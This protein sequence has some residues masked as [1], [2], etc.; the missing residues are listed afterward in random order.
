MG[1]GRIKAGLLFVSG[2]LA[3]ICAGPADAR[4]VNFAI[5]PQPL[6]AALRAFTRATGRSVVLDIPNAANID[7]PGVNG[8]LDEAPALARLLGDRAFDIHVVSGG[9]VVR[10][11]Q[12]RPVVTEARQRRAADAAPIAPE[13]IVVTAQRRSE[14]LLEVPISISTV[15]GPVLLKSGITST[16]FLSQIAPGIVTVNNGFGYLPIVRG[17]Q[18]TGTS[19]GDETNI[20]IYIDDVSIG[21]PIAGFFDLTDLE[22]VEVLKG[23]Q[24]TLYGRNA[25]GGAI[26]LITRRP[27]FD[28]KGSIS[29]DFGFRY[30]DFRA[31][32]YA[33]GKITEQLAGLISATYHVGDGYIRGT[34][35]NAGRSYGGPDNHVV[36]AKLLWQPSSDF[37]AILSG[38]TWRQQNDSVFISELKDRNNPYPLTAGTIP[39][40]PY[41]YASATQPMAKLRGWGSSLDMSWNAP[42]DVMV[43]SLTGYRHVAVN[44]QSDTDRTNLSIGANQISQ[45]QGSLSE[46]LTITS[47]AARKLSW[48]AG[49]YYYNSRAGNPYFRVF[50]GDAPGGN[51][52]S[53]FTDRTKSEVFAGFAEATLNLLDDSFHAT[54]GMRYNS[55]TKIFH[56]DNLVD[57]A[58][59]A[60]DRRRTWHS[61]TWRAVARYD[62]TPDA[63]IYLSASSGFKSGVYNAYSSRGI[64]VNPEKITAFEL[65]AK[66]HAGAFNFTFAGF[67][68]YYRDIQVSAYAYADIPP[69]LQLTLSNAARAR[70]RGLEFTADGKLGG[71]FSF[72]A[73]LS[74]EPTARYMTFTQAQVTAPLAPSAYSV[75]FNGI[76]EATFVPYDASGSRLVRTPQLTGNIRLAYDASLW[77]GAFSGTLNTAYT[78]A[79]YWQP[80]NFSREGGY[81]L[82][83]FRLGWTRNRV[84]WSVF[85]NNVTNKEFF[86]DYVPNARG[87]TVKLQ[88]GAEFGVG[89]SYTF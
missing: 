15:S 11:R 14:R 53:N 1:R 47:A 73:G 86:T 85:G 3:V 67:L 29:G 82:V 68:Y 74:W 19:P 87:D 16:V 5:K 60:V 24:G 64:P 48:I 39:N 35:G 61:A 33:T 54:A 89:I 42:G 69:A 37:Q 21:T 72:A 83:N 45:Y 36:R 18:S 8:A 88:P 70:M 17:I 58:S 41:S 4:A 12:P 2:G 30:K 27:S 75:P 31:S 46:E 79:I 52:I 51:I 34:A 81:A 65:G 38:D 62:L 63:N 50:S 28:T 76:V 80:G 10:L 7:S 55:E 6:I 44:S 40:T 59:P 23:P 32:G 84:T 49:A 78:S 71:G 13:A 26:K 20:A 25:T 56:W 22:R 43:R 77:G 9:Y 66:A 57:L